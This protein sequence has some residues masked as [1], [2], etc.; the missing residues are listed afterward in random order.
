MNIA[1]IGHTRGLGQRIF[2]HYSIDNNVMGF[3]R[4][5]GYDIE[6]SIEDI[7]SGLSNIDM[8]VIN[9]YHAEAQLNILKETYRFIPKI[10]VCGS[11]SRLYGDLI[12][13]DYVTHKT[14]LE[15]F[16]R[17]VNTSPDTHC[18]V[19]HLDLSFIEQTEVDL[20]VP[21]NFTSDFTIG[22][23]EIISSI[24]FWLTCPKVS[25]IEFKWKLTDFVYTQLKR[26]N[27][28]HTNLENLLSTI[29]SI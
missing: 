26:A 21:T 3:S 13:T 1:I 6:K 19:L 23:D 29:K 14:E 2:D 25:N 7:I 8:L 15:K 24:N 10:V 18:D 11:V 28:D 16:C 20:L 9:A 12:K 22:F 17:L 5:N 27:E 4:S